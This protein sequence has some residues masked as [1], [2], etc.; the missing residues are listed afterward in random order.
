MTPNGIGV[1]QMSKASHIDAISHADS[2]TIPDVCRDQA[3]PADIA[4]L[5]DPNLDILER[6]DVALDIIRQVKEHNRSIGLVAPD[7]DT[8]DELRTTSSDDSGP[9]DEPEEVD[10]GEL[11]DFVQD[12]L[13]RAAAAKEMLRKL[14][15]NNRQAALSSRPKK[16]MVEGLENMVGE[17]VDNADDAVEVLRL[18]AQATDLNQIVTCVYVLFLNSQMR[19]VGACCVA[20][21]RIEDCAV[22]PRAIFRLA[23]EHGATK[24]VVGNTSPSGKIGFSE[25]TSSM[26]QRMIQSGEILGI[27]MS[28]FIVFSD[29]DFTSWWNHREKARKKGKGKK[30]R[31]G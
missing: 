27:Q 19:L 10:G 9:S 2:E 16:I 23:I 24:I 3:N 6:A 17:Q 31:I 29:D 21:G 12:L 30:L 25:E 22:D 1:T 8:D 13:D 5:G 15:E 28:D 20:M 4:K 14:N 26:V 11:F 7:D 18:V